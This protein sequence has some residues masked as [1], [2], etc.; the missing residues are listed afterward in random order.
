MLNRH[1]AELIKKVSPNA[2]ASDDLLEMYVRHTKVIESELLQKHG[3]Q[4]SAGSITFIPS[5][6]T[7]K[8]NARS[9]NGF[10]T[11]VLA[12]LEERATLSLVHID[13]L[14]FSAPARRPAKHPTRGARTP[15]HGIATEFD[16]TT[17]YQACCRAK[18]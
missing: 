6:S 15:K 11:K 2:E 4:K 5:D 10:E 13:Y 12:V 16:S 8:S 1:L 9:R 14:L 18:V 7:S 3:I 17:H